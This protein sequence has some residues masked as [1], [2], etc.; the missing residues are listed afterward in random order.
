MPIF[1]YHPRNQEPTDKE[2]EKK[3][4]KYSL[5]FSV[6]IVGIFWLVKL[7][8]NCLGIDLAEYGI[9]PLQIEE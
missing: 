7:I 9:L 1:D 2:T 6:I 5:L 3:I 8:E 4:F